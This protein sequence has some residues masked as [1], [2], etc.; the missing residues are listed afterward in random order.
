MYYVYMLR[1]IDNSLYT[2]TTNDVNKRY[3]KHLLGTG[4]KYTR[5]HKPVSIELI[6]ECVSKSEALKLERKIKSLR[7][8]QKEQLIL[9]DTKVINN[10]DIHIQNIKKS[11]E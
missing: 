10:L 4:A 9:K 5:A 6:I 11:N 7:K 2:G 8:S 3:E 1:C